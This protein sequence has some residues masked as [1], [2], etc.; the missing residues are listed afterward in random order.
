M[1]EDHSDAPAPSRLLA[2]A[3][4]AVAVLMALGAAGLAIFMPYLI[5]SGGIETAR[6]FL[7]LTPAFFPSLTMGLLAVVCVPYAIGAVRGLAKS[8]EAHTADDLSRLKRAGFMF[9]IAVFYAG[10]MS[11]M[12]FILSTMLVAFVVSYF[13]GLRKPLA[14]LPAVAIAPILIRFMFERWLYIALPRS[15]IGFVA[16]AEDA[17]IHFLLII[18]NA[19]LSVIEY[20]LTAVQ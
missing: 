7:T 14:F 15:E 4:V 2:R 12:G 13:L 18:Q 16:A 6:E 10:V 19:V 8:N 1:A 20:L 17:L 9:V 11:W 3:E 5:G